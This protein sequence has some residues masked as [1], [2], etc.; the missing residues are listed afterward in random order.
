MSIWQVQIYK[1]AIR[2]APAESMFQR[3][4]DSLFSSMP[5]ALSVA[6][7]IL[8]AGSDRQ[9][10]NHDKTLDK[11][12]WISRQLN[13]KLNK[14]KSLFRCPSIPFPGKIISWQG[15]SLNQ[16]KFQALREMLPPNCKKWSIVISGKLN[17][18]NAFTPVTADIYKPLQKLTLV[19]VD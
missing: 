2:I 16:S 17:Y 15:V 13:L 12:L 3:K 7:D 4:V 8:I 10:K 5:N 14:G 19:K 18:Q 6:D 1:I 11:A 9:G